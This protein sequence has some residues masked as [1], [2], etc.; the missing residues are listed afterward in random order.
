MNGAQKILVILIHTSYTHAS[1]HRMLLPITMI[2][3]EASMIFHS[4]PRPRPQIRPIT[5]YDWPS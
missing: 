1:E 2:G 5:N 4:P 3:R